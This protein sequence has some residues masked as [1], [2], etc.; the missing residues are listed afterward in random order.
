MSE[1]NCYLC[2]EQVFKGGLKTQKSEVNLM[3][4]LFR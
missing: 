1:L 4:W 2:L 3:L